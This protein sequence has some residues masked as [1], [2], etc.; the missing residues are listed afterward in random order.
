MGSTWAPQS[1]LIFYWVIYDISISK[2]T[3]VNFLNKFFIYNLA[4]TLNTVQCGK[5]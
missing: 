4:E 5:N 2:R 1:N 3:L